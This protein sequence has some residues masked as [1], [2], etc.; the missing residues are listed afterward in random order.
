MLSVLRLTSQDA[1]HWGNIEIFTPGEIG[2]EVLII[3]RLTLEWLCL[4]L[5]Y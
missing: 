2:E 1:R 3:F 5:L 4:L